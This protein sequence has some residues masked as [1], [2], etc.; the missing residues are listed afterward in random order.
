MNLTG[1]LMDLAGMLSYVPFRDPLATE[2]YWLL[3]LLPLVI[4]LSVVYKTL[5]VD[6]L[7]KLPREVTLF[8]VKVFGYIVCGVAILW[9]LTEY[10]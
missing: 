4:G 10:L 3:W 5:N 2:E 1:A 9:S 8:A 6:D 7:S